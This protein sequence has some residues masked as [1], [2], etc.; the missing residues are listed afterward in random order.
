MHTVVA[1]VSL[2]DTSKL[3]RRLSLGT[4]GG[5]NPITCGRLG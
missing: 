5:T 2:L 1:P 3:W 4:P